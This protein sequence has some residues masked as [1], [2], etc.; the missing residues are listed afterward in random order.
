MNTKIFRLTAISL[1]TLTVLSLV[2]CGSEQINISEQSSADADISLT[3]KAFWKRGRT[4]SSGGSPD[5][6]F[7]FIE[8][9]IKNNGQASLSFDMAEGKFIG[10]RGA[11]LTI[12]AYNTLGQEAGYQYTTDFNPGEEKVFEFST[13]TYGYL[14]YENGEFQVTLFLE[15]KSVA[16]PFRAKLPSLHEL[17]AEFIRD[18]KDMAGREMTEV[19][20]DFSEVIE[21]APK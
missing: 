9:S 2:A 18:N 10:E 8:L 14:P 6:D 13:E 4:N 12:R 3:G 15:D 17:P 16:G 5:P 20:L 1:L 19:F 7:Y 21:S 11:E